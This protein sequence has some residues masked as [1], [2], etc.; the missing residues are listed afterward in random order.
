MI[1]RQT[2][3]AAFLLFIGYGVLLS[4]FT[5]VDTYHS[6]FFATGTSVIVYNLFRIL[7]IGYSLWLYYSLGYLFLSLFKIK[8][9]IAERTL[10]WYLL[11]FFTGVGLSQIILF[12]IGLAG[13]YNRTLMSCATLFVFI[14]SLPELSRCLISSQKSPSR[15][16][17]LGLMIISAALFGFIITKGL[18]PSGGHDYYTHYFQYYRSVVE[19]GSTLPNEVWYHFYYSKGS[20]LFFLS[21]LLTDPLGPQL[22]TTT[23][24]IAGAAII[25]SIIRGTSSSRLL[26]WLAVAL[27][28]AFFIYTPGP[29]ENMRQGGWGDLEKSHEPA[30][31]LLLA[32]LWQTIGLIKQSGSRLWGISLL[33]TTSGL[34]LI[35]PSL[36]LFSGVFFAFNMVYLF[37]KQHKSSSYWMFAAGATTGIWVIFQLAINYYLTG[38]PDDHGILSFWPFINFEKITNWGVLLELVTAHMAITGLVANK[39]GISSG[40]IYKIF[41]YLRL[42]IWG[43]LMLCSTILLLFAALLKKR[44]NLRM[45]I[46]DKTAVF[47]FGSFLLMVIILSILIGRDEHISYYRFTTF[48]YAPVLCFS[49][50]LIPKNLR[51]L[52]SMT[53]LAMFFVIWKINYADGHIQTIIKNGL[54]F[55]TGVYSIAD[56]YRNQQGLPGRMPWGGIN[57]SAE[58][59]WKELPLKTRVWSM[60]MHTY[61]M[62][63]E[64]GIE[65]YQSYRL[66]LHADEVYFGDPVKAKKI[67]QEESLNYFFFSDTLQMADPLPR[68]NLFSPRNIS[69]FL[70][71]VWTDGENTLLTWKENA[72]IAIDKNWLNK[73]ESAINASPQVKGFRKKDVQYVVDAIKK[74]KGIK[75]EDIPWYHAGWK[76]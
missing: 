46:L 43:I 24:M 18:Y 33:L 22:A 5:L 58:K 65:S 23:L 69:R 16:T 62:L 63:P 35:S 3:F 12:F 27:Y 70:G 52:G 9:D 75:Q 31:I 68:S 48:T 13:L 67:L 37:L 44:L 42:D 39:V 38:L 71:I 45:T 55:S 74:N 17:W 47:V 29:D 19:S 21:M 11:H 54:N 36:C 1:Y 10:N 61:C 32:I 60:H 2:S 20:G 25:F 72:T 6:A 51:I 76:A 53:V 26:P 66:S 73:Y 4:Y 40:L 56:A 15:L 14:C 30:A 41:T 57:P 8:N 7:F 49:L 28:F 50:L 34:M 64:C 59:I